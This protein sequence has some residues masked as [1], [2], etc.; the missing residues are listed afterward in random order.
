M[1]NSTIIIGLLFLLTLYTLSSPFVQE[2]Q[3]AFF[4]EWY[5][6]KQDLRIMDKIL[7]EC[8][9]FLLDTTRDKLWNSFETSSK[10]E[11]I[12]DMFCL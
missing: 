4:G 5:E 11:G 6:V 7:L 12:D 10:L 1:V 3:S 9:E 2:E 8:N